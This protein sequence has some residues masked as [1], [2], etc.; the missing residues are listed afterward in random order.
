MSVINLEN[1]ESMQYISQN[2]FQNEEENEPEQTQQF[3]MGGGNKIYNYI[4]N[5]K[6]NSKVK[7]DSKLGT[8]N[9][10]KYVKY[11]NK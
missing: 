3:S 7:I 11:Q 8:E 6:T 5:P 4:I 2:E 1:T 10:K 9:I